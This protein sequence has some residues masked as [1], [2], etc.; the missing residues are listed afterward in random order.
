MP[1]DN[2]DN[3][4]NDQTP[5][6]ASE[7][8]ILLTRL[9][10]QQATEQDQLRFEQ[11]AEDDPTL[12][13]TLAEQQQ[14][15]AA[16]SDTVIEQLVA[17]D[18]VELPSRR[19]SITPIKPFAFIGWAAAI[20]IA[21]VWIVIPAKEPIGPTTVDLTAGQHRE[22]Y[23]RAEFV[24]SD[25]D[26]VLLDTEVMEDGRIKLYYMRRHEEWV[27]TNR[28]KD[29]ILNGDKFKISPEELRKETTQTWLIIDQ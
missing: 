12:W 3:S 25:F 23:E 24:N 18:R 4:N 9:V 19:A 26:P 16:L 5:E 17:A 13:R 21:A 11:L 8:E 27:I 20:I 22:E 15:M 14:E 6:T 10:D 1:N 2:S 29:E 28:P 7:A